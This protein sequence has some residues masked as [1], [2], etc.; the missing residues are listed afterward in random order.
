M[1]LD[2]CKTFD[3]VNIERLFR[4]LIRLGVPTHMIEVK[5]SLYRDPEF[6]VQDRFCRTTTAKRRGGLRQGAPMSG[7]LFIAMLTVIMQDEEEDW[8]RSTVEKDSIARDTVKDTVGRDFALYADDL[9]T[10]CIR[11]MRA[12]LHSILREGAL[13]GKFFQEKSE[14]QACVPGRFFLMKSRCRV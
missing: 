7:F 8:K 9:V 11:T 10:G 14:E 5:R 13:Y 1:L 4:A 2:W 3:K 12:V 6:Y